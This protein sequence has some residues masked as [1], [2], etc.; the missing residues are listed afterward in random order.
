M[1]RSLNSAST[2]SFL[3][4]R[5]LLFRRVSR[6]A[7]TLSIT[8][9]GRGVPA[10]EMSSNDSAIS[11]NPLMT[12]SFSWTLPST[13]TTDSRDT[14]AIFSKS[15]GSFFLITVTWKTPSRSRIMMNAIPPRLRTS[16]IQPAILIF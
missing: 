11:S 16:C 15:S 12:S 10:S 9:S 4:S 14:F 2:F 3:R 1:S 6:S 5:N 7:P 8:P 13:V